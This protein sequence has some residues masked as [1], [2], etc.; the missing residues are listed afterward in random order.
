MDKLNDTQIQRIINSQVKRKERLTYADSCLD[1]SQD[2]H[3][4]SQ[5]VKQLHQKFNS[6]SSPELIK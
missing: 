5:Q 3:Y 1:N 4:L 6:L 2:K